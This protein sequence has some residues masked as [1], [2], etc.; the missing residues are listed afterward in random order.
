MS[1]LT[2]P[3]RLPLHKRVPPGAWAALAWCAG[4]AFTFL[5]RVRLP[6]E[7]QPGE[8][9]SAQFFRWE[10][11][12]HTA[13]GTALALTGSGLLRRRPLVALGLLIAATVI[14]TTALGVGE[15]QLP[16]FLAVAVALYAVAVSLP[17]RVSAI[18]GA[19]AVAT[20]VVHGFVRLTMGWPIGTSTLV[21]VALTA[22]VAWLLG[23]STR[24]AR[25]HAV[26][27]SAQ[28]AA[29]AVTAE[30][31]RIAREMHD[32]VAHSIGIIALQAGAAARVIETQP[33]RA[34]DALSE[35]ETAGRETLSGLRRMLGALR[36]A[37]P[38]GHD[39]PAELHPAPGLADLEDLA[40]A[41]TAAGV[42]VEVLWEGERRQLPP[43][44]DLSAYR[45]IQ[46][47]ITNV[48]RHSGADS[49]RVTV[50]GGPGEL[51]V[52][53]VDDG[54]GRGAP[55]DPGFGLVGMRERVSLLHGE[56]SA[57]PRPGGGFRVAAKLPL[58]AMVSAGAR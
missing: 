6:G 16:Q 54:R 28:A 48:V 38:A 15:I 2:A 30:R 27:L 4:L 42:R 23:D 35:V 29:Q 18:A 45:I 26:Q 40:A 9:A 5:V 10:G 13:L 1:T 25:E 11:L 44:V 33:G 50:S 32:M 17:Q 37:E 3:P 51:S 8:Q 55:S 46:E 47:S 24:Q 41:T 39:A 31:L 43:E 36:Q 14:S 19:L 22:L 56:F 34:R 12:M 49:C 53:I 20:P 58:P 7:S 21:A 57:A 52:E